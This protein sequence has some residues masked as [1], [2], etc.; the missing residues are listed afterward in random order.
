MY[1][2]SGISLLYTFG[3]ISA[4]S[5]KAEKGRYCQ[6]NVCG[7]TAVDQISLAMSAM[8]RLSHLLPSPP[9]LS[10]S[11]LLLPPPPSNADAARA[12]TCNAR[13]FLQPQLNKAISRDHALER[14]DKNLKDWVVF[15]YV[16][17]C[18]C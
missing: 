18:T 4:L 1:T 13:T 7:L 2:L 6:R 11:P 5:K 3:G 9:L 15:R 14:A 10:S 8:G 17:S 16:F 12:T